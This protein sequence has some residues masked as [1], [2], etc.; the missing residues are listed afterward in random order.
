MSKTID[1]HQFTLL[2]R[3]VC[4][5]APGILQ[6]LSDPSHK[7]A[8]LLHA[9]FEKVCTFLNI[10]SKTPAAELGD[11]HGYAFQ[12]LEEHMHPEFLVFGHCRSRAPVPCS[13]M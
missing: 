9:L 5:V 11:D 13:L 6:N 2:C 1:E 12:T 7:T 3:E 8:R 10:D 4:R